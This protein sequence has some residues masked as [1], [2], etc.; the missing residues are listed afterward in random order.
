MVAVIDVDDDDDVEGANGRMNAGR[1][2][3]TTR[4]A[5]A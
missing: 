2:V 1:E 5:A 3:D 4:R